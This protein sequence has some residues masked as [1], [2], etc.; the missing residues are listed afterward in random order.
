MTKKQLSISV[1][2][3]DRITRVMKRIMASIGGLIKRVGRAAKGVRKFALSFKGLAT[4]AAALFVG[5][6]IISSIRSTVDELDKLGKT[7]KDIGLTAEQMSV[8]TVAADRNGLALDGLVQSL[9]KFR[10]RFSLFVESG[11]GAGAKAFPVLEQLGV[12]LRNADGSAR[13]VNEVFDD[14]VKAMSKI[15]DEAVATSLA[16]QL[17]GDETGGTVIRFLRNYETAAA[18]AASTGSIFTEETFRLAAEANDAFS[19]IDEAMRSIR[20][21]IV[22]A[23]GEDGVERVNQFARAL[24][25]VPTVVKTIVDSIGT[26]LGQGEEA[27]RMQERFA[28]LGE[29][30]IRVL[31]ETVIAGAPV[32]FFAVSTVVGSIVSSMGRVVGDPLRKS[33]YDVLTDINHDLASLYDG[34]PVLEVWSNMARSSADRFFELSNSISSSGVREQIASFERNLNEAVSTGGI[35]NEKLGESRT[36]ISEAAGEFG[37]LAADML[38]LGPVLEDIQKK[39][40]GVTDSADNS[41]KAGIRFGDAFVQGVERVVKP[42]LE[43]SNIAREL[44]GAITNSI[45]NNTVSAVERLQDG[46]A[47]AKEVFAD[48]ARSVLRDIQ[49]IAIRAAVL[50]IFGGLFNI[51]P[52][53][54]PVVPGSSPIP[55]TAFANLG[56]RIMNSGV[57]R[58]YNAGSYSVPGPALNR[59]LVPALLSPGERVMSRAEVRRQDRKQAGGG[60]VVNQTIHVSGNSNPQDVLRAAKEG[61]LEAIRFDPTYRSQVRGVLA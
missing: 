13:A 60:V 14:T 9:Q 50:N 41:G 16:F 28:D 17:F 39:L 20:V 58:R 55:G 30:G 22:T 15:T 2:A 56:G 37:T 1:E 51:R 49:A 21:R 43:V 10:K 52:T 35:L 29:A 33:L 18:D 31:S 32:L 12:Q 48:F 38:N 7:R 54:G 42:L 5:G 24:A 53:G 45:A 25:K 57:V 40:E 4:G 47:K 6:K 44:G 61:V 3:K 59:D 46:A 36:R 19:R 27:K 23:F 8:L 26:A 34:I 11:G